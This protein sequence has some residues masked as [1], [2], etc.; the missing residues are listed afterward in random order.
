MTH[1][2]DVVRLDHAGARTFAERIV[3]G[4]STSDLGGDVRRSE[5]ITFRPS[6][7]KMVDRWQ[8]RF[9]PLPTLVLDDLIAAAMRHDQSHLG[10]VVVAGKSYLVGV[11]FALDTVLVVG[12]A[13]G[14]ESGKLG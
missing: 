6:G 11:A 14:R 13:G 4:I 3:N 5:P 9:A 10:A 1:S 12:T 8:A 7:H 2:W